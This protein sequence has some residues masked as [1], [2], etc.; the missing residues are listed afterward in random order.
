MVVGIDK[1]REYFKEYPGSYVIIGGTAC[2]MI[3]DA[4]GF[5]PRAT[6]DIDIVLVIE[7]LKQEFGKQFWKFVEDGKYEVKEKSSEER[8]Y[9]RFMKPANAE[10]PKQ[11]EI[12]CRTPDLLDLDK[13]AHLAPIPIAEGVP[14]LSAILMDDEYYGFTL[15]YT[16]AE[17]EVN[18]ANP[19]AL[20]CLKAKAFLDLT[21]RKNKGEEISD[22]EI[23]KHKNDVFRMALMLTEAQVFEL[24][25][26]IKT[27]M[28]AFADAVKTDLPG[29]EIF[30]AMGAPGTNA[31]NLFA[32]M[33][34]N[35]GL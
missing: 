15:K 35:F 30:D 25:A 23:K 13:A 29:K 26:G 22:K 4:A 12:F 18:R 19:E 11:V 1:F 17:G 24:P 8:K 20:V 7:A 34:K 3:M 31:E 2:D 9:Y 10:F 14:S 27:D 21:G 16:T 6:K 28:K 33:M 5:V 32:Q